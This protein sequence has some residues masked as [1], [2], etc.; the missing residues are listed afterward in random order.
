MTDYPILPDLAT[1]GS[2]RRPGRP[3][4]K[5]EFIVAH[6]TGNPGASAR[7]HARWYRNDPN[8]PAN[9]VSSAHLFVDDLNIV[10]TVP[11]LTEAPEQAL[12]VLY[13]VTTDNAL[14]GFDANR[15]AIGVE[16]CYG[17]N[18]A[19]DAAYDRFVFVLARLCKVFSLDPATRITGHHVLDPVRK[20]DPVGGLAASGRTY[21]GLLTDVAARFAAVG[22]NPAA[23]GSQA[24][25]VG[26]ARATVN[27]NRRREP[28]GAAVRTGGF[29]PG[30]GVTVA[31]VVPGQRVMGNDRWCRLPEGDFCWSGGLVLA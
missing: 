15:A 30:D 28:T 25:R 23:I 8:P 3:I 21:D 4:T 26:A 9:R 31:E 6:D 12:H 5:V 17:G 22:G 18:I 13:S 1:L 20:T 14:F 16:Y 24:V 2:R 11:A 27:L 7:A 19:A 10:E 29:R